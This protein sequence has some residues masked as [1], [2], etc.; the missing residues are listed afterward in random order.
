MTCRQNWKKRKQKAMY[1]VTDM[2]YSLFPPDVW[3]AWQNFNLTS[4][5]FVAQLKREYME[6]EQC[7]KT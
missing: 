2:E 6:E 4:K 7:L 1:G 3:E 5:R